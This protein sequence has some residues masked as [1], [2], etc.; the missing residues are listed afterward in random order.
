MIRTTQL[1]TTRI[2]T[3]VFIVRTAHQSTREN[4]LN[5]TIQVDE[6]T[7][8]TAVAG[9]VSFDEDGDPYTSGEATVAT[10]VAQ[11]ITAHLIKDEQWRS[12]RDRMLEIRAEVIREALTPVVEKTLTESFQKTNSYGEP[13]GGQISMRQVIADEAKKLMTQSADTYNRDKGTLLQVMVR[14]EVEAALGSEIRD[15]V[16]AARQ[17]VSDEIGA[18]VAKSVAAGMSR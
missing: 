6:V 2:T 3:R 15:A 10:L 5:I 16:K 9:V 18:M 13:V 1:L 12:L 8:D 4:P 17:Q 11:Q 14:K 7:L